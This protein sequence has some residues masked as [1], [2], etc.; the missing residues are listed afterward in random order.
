MTFKSQFFL[1]IIDIHKSLNR[2]LDHLWAKFRAKLVKMATCG[3]NW[4]VRDAFLNFIS[5]IHVKFTLYSTCILL[6]E[7]Y[8]TLSSW[9]IDYCKPNSIIKIVIIPGPPAL[10][11][12]LYLNMDY[13]LCVKKG[14]TRENSA[15]VCLYLNLFC[16]DEMFMKQT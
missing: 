12:F 13:G 7:Y 10:I 9:W 11:N 2:L 4:L 16:H 3:N 14:P 6:T 8:K 1:F 5:N 15:R